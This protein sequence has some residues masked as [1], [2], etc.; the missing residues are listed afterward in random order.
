MPAVLL[1]ACAGP[2]VVP[3]RPVRPDAAAR[4]F[5]AEMTTTRPDATYSEKLYVGNG[6]VRLDSSGSEHLV[7]ILHDF[8]HRTT[9]FLVPE[10]LADFHLPDLDPDALRPEGYF[11]G[12][13]GSPCAPEKKLLRCERIGESQL[14]TFE[15][16]EWRIEEGPAD[17]KTSTH[18]WIDKATRVKVKAVSTGAK[19]LTTE[20][21]RL[22]MGHQPDGLF[23]VPADYVLHMQAREAPH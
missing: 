7:I 20:I 5:S 21:T 14:G 2:R 3:D 4:E 19:T 12:D 8:D 6:R 18:L 17:H 15:T 22:S 10:Q 1:I 11:A 23:E 9:T 13:G 16:A